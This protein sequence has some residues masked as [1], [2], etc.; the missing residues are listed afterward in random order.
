MTAVDLYIVLVLMTGMGFLHIWFAGVV[1]KDVIRE[2][3]EENF[4][5]LERCTRHAPDNLRQMNRV[6]ASDN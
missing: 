2:Y 3:F 1:A 6:S 5:Y 4:Q